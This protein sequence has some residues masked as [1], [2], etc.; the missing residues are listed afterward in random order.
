V[1]LQSP[2]YGDQK[3]YVSDCMKLYPDKILATFG[4][5][6]P[7]K[8]DTTVDEIDK[9][10]NLYSC[11]GIKIEIPDVPFKID[12]PEYDF[13]WR[14]IVEDDLLVVLDLGFGD[15]EY[16]F[17]I[18][19]LT[20]VINRYPDIKM[21]LPHLGI[22]RLWDLSQKNPYPELQKTLKL[23]NINKK[24]LYIDI[25]AIQFFDLNDEHPDKRNQDIVKIVYETIGPDKIL[26]GTDFPT[27]LKLRT[28]RQ[29]L[30][31]VINQCDFLTYE[32]KI[33]ILGQNALAVYGE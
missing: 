6:D 28:I 30:D 18:E 11:S 19:R 13:L 20:N 16:D 17:N 25:A 9:L 14:K 3:E 4:K 1:V 12:A 8:R 22:S 21:V 33:K 32:D 23:F 2:C 15:G 24:N 5:L 10:V 26:W 7:R 27:I 31:F 29:C